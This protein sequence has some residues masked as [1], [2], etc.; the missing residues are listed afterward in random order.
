MK[1]YVAIGD[2]VL[3]VYHDASNQ[4][5]GY[6]AGGSVWNDLLNISSLG[7]NANCFCI[8]TCGNDWAG[9]F[10][11]DILH[12]NG[13]DISNVKS[14]HRQTKRFN[15]IISGNQ[16]KSQLE[17][18]CC[19]EKIWYSD[20]K[21]PANIP[22]NLSALK[23]G[24]VI[25]DTLKRGVLDLANSFR[26]AGWFLVA[27]IGYISHLRYMSL[28]NVKDLLCQKFDLVQVNHNV[29]QFL[30][31]RFS[32]N[33][34]GDLLS[35]LGVKYLSVTNAE[36][37]STFSYKNP[38]GC[39]ETTA[40]EARSTSVVD[41]TGAGDAYFS[42]ILQMLPDEGNFI[43]DINDIMS[44]AAIYASKRVSVIG[45]TGRLKSSNLIDGDCKACGS[46]KKNIVQKRISRKTI[47]TNANNLLD[48]TFRALESNACQRL[49]QV[50]NTLSGLLLMVGTGGSY[51]AAEFA[52]KCI[53]EFHPNAVACSYHPRDLFVLGL[54]KVKAVFLFSYSGKT[55]DIQ[56]VYNLCKSNGIPAYLITK[57]DYDEH[58]TLYDEESIISYNVSK[59]RSKE[60]GFISMAGT[61]I[62][63]C[64]FGEIYYKNNFWN[65]KEFLNN[66]FEQRRIEF[67]NT[68]VFANLPKRNILIDLFSGAD[69]K[70]AAIDLESKFIESG[71]ARVIVHEKKDF[72][73]GRFNII[74]EFR[75]DMIIILEGMRGAYTE[76]LNQYFS[77]REYTNILRIVSDYG[78]IWGDLD[79]LIASEFLSKH[80][81]VAL[82]YDMARP[83]YP[84]TAMTLYRYCRK[85]LL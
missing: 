78:Y 6:Y 72:S 32:C 60:R 42:K 69:T 55:S 18:P 50:L 81:S 41:P 64:I 34:E 21:L 75:P 85:D 29:Y 17:C 2:L 59:S 53:N 48:R 16:T 37:G 79:L 3:D 23:P 13:I 54:K 58:D 52:S 5:L 83:N 12:E 8:A 65:F 56:M 22:A 77:K 20:T 10:V 39:V 38:Y 68:D 82:D 1:N 67:A 30:S 35:A 43:R 24:V 40:C 51:A 44:E 25:V 63:M 15:I 80:L 47:A 45:A 4:V 11:L 70:C 33:N 19:G 27:D 14:L 74:E 61:L 73:H 66:C 84:E 26:D 62:P 46:I 28:S 31:R 36:N 9:K 57:Y 7:N 76:K 71:L 49:W